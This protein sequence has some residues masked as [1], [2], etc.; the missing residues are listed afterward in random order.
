MTG[1]FLALPPDFSVAAGCHLAGRKLAV[2]ATVPFA[3]QIGVRRFQAVGQNDNLPVADRASMTVFGALYDASLPFV[4]S[5]PGALPPN[6]FS[7][8]G[9]NVL[10]SQRAVTRTMPFGRD[11]GKLHAKAIRL[12]DDP[13]LAH[14]A[15]IAVFGQR[16]HATS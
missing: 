7:A 14:R 13:V 1:V 8:S 16:N 11:G 5:A 6:L 15:A 9:R 12:Y 2:L 10:W 4:V 3:D